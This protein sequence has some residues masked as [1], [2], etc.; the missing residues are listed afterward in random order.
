MTCMVVEGREPGSLASY[1][2]TQRSASL[3]TWDILQACTLETFC[4]L[5]NLEHCASLRILQA[6][7]LW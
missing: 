3:Q 2:K 7:E 5:A 1:A 4:K 6:C